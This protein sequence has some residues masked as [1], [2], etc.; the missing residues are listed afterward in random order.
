MPTVAR[1]RPYSA[2]IS[3]SKEIGV[4]TGILP[5]VQVGDGPMLSRPTMNEV[6]RAMGYFKVLQADGTLVDAKELNLD[7]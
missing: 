3:T 1:P 4:A 5:V 6:R 7:A 2:L